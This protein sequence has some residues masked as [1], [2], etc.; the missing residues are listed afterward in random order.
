M[1]PYAI[2]GVI[3][4]VA[5]AILYCAPAAAGL[6]FQQDG[7]MEDPLKLI[8]KCGAMVIG[9]G[10]VVAAVGFARDWPNR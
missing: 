7:Q 2:A 1:K 6:L 10:L 4:I 8:S 9:L 5:G 3:L